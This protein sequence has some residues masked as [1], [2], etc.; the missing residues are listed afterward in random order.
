[1]DPRVKTSSEGLKAQF[2]MEL[3][4]VEAMHRDFDALTEV[5]TVRKALKQISS[6]ANLQSRVAELDKKLAEV[7]GTAGG[8]GAQ[9]LGT[10]AARGLARLNS[11]LSTL[12]TIVDSADAAPTTQAI[13]AFAEV[14]RALDE[15]LTRWADL[16]NKDLPALNQQLKQAG[17][18]SIEAPVEKK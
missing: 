18:S 14:Q 1:M 11:G 7:E 8:Y 13:A 5:Q 12:L 16:R 17:V 2:E 4:I 10:P 9:Y 15:Q 6:P 3:K